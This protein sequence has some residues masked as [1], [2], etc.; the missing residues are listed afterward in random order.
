MIT[1]TST[2]TSTTKIH[3]SHSSPTH[4]GIS[5]LEVG[6]VTV[7]LALAPELVVPLAALLLGVCLAGWWFR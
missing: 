6:S 2:P 3:N 5:D 4:R 7:T 1:S